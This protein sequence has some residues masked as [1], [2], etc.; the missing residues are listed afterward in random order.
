MTFSRSSS[1]VRPKPSHSGHAPIGLLAENSAGVGSGKS[2]PQ[3]EQLK[4]RSKAA[5]ATGVIR[6]F[7]RTTVTT[8]A[9]PPPR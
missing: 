6:P 7:S 3:V 8:R 9:R 5:S 1:T 4:R 2:V